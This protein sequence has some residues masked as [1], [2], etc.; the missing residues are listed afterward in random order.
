MIV[1]YLNFLQIM[2]HKVECTA[3]IGSSHGSRLYIWGGANS[4]SS[5]APKLPPNFCSTALCGQIRLL[6]PGLNYHMDAALQR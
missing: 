4:T 1:I 2:L 5:G 3:S 6:K